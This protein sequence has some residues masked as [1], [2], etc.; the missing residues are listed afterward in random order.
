M[1]VN[2]PIRLSIVRTRIARPG[3]DSH[4]LTITK[5]IR[6]RVSKRRGRIVYNSHECTVMRRNKPVNSQIKRNT[7]WP[8]EKRRPT[9]RLR[10]D[11]CVD[12]WGPP[13]LG[14]HLIWS[15][16]TKAGVVLHLFSYYDCLLCA[17]VR[18]DDSLDTPHKKRDCVFIAS[19][20]VGD[21]EDNRGS[22]ISYSI[23]SSPLPF[24]IL[25][26]IPLTN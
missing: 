9:R 23:I 16:S 4:F 15:R 25:D 11:I 19:H 22:I 6:V 3:G 13:R 24:E 18:L 1:S 17:D 7:R 12:I 5:P 8:G 14:K 20:L 21:D 26:F 10:C 2:F